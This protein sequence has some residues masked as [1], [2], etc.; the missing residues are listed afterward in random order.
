MNETEERTFAAHVRGFAP[1]K[2]NELRCQAHR[3]VEVQRAHMLA[4]ERALFPLGEQ[5]L[6]HDVL[7]AMSR[8]LRVPNA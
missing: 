5:S 1:G 7:V 3:F 4:E 2:E 8:E 6:P